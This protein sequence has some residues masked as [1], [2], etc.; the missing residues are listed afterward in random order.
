MESDEG[1]VLMNVITNPYVFSCIYP[2]YVYT[3]LMKGVKKSI[4]MCIYILKKDI[5]ESSL[6][7]RGEA[8]AVHEPGSRFSSDTESACASTLDHPASRTSRNQ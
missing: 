8:K 5:T 7:T 1:G 3:V 4:Y 6:H 2:I